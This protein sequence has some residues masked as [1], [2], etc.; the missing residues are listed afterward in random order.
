[1]LADKIF[2]NYQYYESPEAGFFLWL[3]INNAKK[4]VKKVFHNYSIKIMPGEYLAAG[5]KKNPGNNYVRIALVHSYEKNK[6]RYANYLSRSLWV[7]KS[8]PFD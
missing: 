4:F 5:N 8:S 3:K 2:S 1:M 6:K 7:I